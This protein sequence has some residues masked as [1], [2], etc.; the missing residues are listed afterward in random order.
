MNRKKLNN[1]PYTAH[2]LPNYLADH[3]TQHENALNFQGSL[4]YLFFESHR[5]EKYLNLQVIGGV[6]KG[7]STM[8]SHVLDEMH[9]DSVDRPSTGPSE[10]TMEPCPYKIKDKMF[11]WD[12]PGLGGIF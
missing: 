11:L 9:V 3:G 1:E 10:S 8:V 7:K 2:P 12:M 6:C 4:N 5:G